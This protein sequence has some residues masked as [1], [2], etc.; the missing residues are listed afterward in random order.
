MLNEYGKKDRSGYSFRLCHLIFKLFG[1]SNDG[2]NPWEGKW[3][4][5]IMGVGNIDLVIEN[6][7]PEL[8]KKR[9]YKGWPKLDN[10][11][12]NKRMEWLRQCIEET[13]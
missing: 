8:S 1:I 9:P 13:Y 10:D 6:Y 5:D 3:Y 4:I 7:F 2:F 11:G 12:K